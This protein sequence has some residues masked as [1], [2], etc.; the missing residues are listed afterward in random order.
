MATDYGRDLSCITDLSPL[1]TEATGRDVVIEAALRRIT[2]ARGMAIDCPNDGTDVGSLL[3][4]EV[5]A[6]DVARIRANVEGELVK[7]DRIFSASVVRMAFVAA[8]GVLTMAIRLEDADGP[9]TLTVDVSSLTV[10][11]LEVS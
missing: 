1:M 5:G 3:S 7:D 2:T 8:T 6:G 9:F 11:L 4:H 10:Q